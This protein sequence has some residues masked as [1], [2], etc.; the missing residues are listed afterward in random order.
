MLDK[1]NQSGDELHITPAQNRHSSITHSVPGKHL[2]VLARVYVIDAY[3]A[4][5][6]KMY[7]CI[8]VLTHGKDT[9]YMY[10]TLKA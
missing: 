2:D 10:S 8:W 1:T 5:F 7:T 9:M 6:L 4:G 3:P